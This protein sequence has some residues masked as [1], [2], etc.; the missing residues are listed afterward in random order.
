MAN[1]VAK[2]F[3]IMPPLFTGAFPQVA[4]LNIMAFHRRTSAVLSAIIFNAI[5]IIPFIPLALKGIKFRPSIFG[6]RSSAP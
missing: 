4:P 3:A 5:I 2:Y 6:L 1:D